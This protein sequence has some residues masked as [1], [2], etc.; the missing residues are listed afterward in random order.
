MKLLVQTTSFVDDRI[1]LHAPE[2]AANGAVVPVGVLSTVPNT[3]KIVLLVNNHTRAKVAE[4]DTS[5][6]K[7]AARLSTHLQLQHAAEITALVQSENRWYRQSTHVKTLG[8]TCE[9]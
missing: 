4:L 6:K 2:D 5:H 9:P 1:E 3:K 8:E 7:M